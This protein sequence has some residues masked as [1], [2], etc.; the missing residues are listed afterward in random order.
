MAERATQHDV[1]NDPTADITAAESNQSTAVIQTMIARGRRN[2]GEIAAVVQANPSA[3]REILAFLH[4]TLGNGFVQAVVRFLTATPSAAPTVEAVAGVEEPTAAPVAGG[5]LGELRVTAHGL[6]VRSSPSATGHDNIVGSLHHNAMINGLGREGAWV[7]IDF[8][9]KTA[10]VH[11]HYVEPISKKK[12]AEA[13][14]GVGTPVIPKED[15][16]PAPVAPTPDAKVVAPTPVG[17]APVAPTPTPV[18]PTPDAK[19]VAPTPIIAP[20]PVVAPVPDAKPPA[21]EVSH[22]P[23]QPQPEA[24][25]VAPK[26]SAP[27]QDGPPKQGGAAIQKTYR[28]PG[29]PTVRAFLPPGGVKGTVD[30]FMFFHGMYAHHDA[31]SKGVDDPERE[32]HMAEAVAGSG[33][34]LVALAP[35]AEMTK[36]E[37]PMWSA[38]NK[39]QGYSQIVEHC[40]Q[41]L[42][43]DFSSDPALT[44]GAISLA[45]HS[46]GG[47]ALG[48]AAE[49][50]GDA[51]HD[52]TLQDGGYGSDAFLGSHKKL[53][54]WFLTGQADKL[55]RVITH[56]DPGKVNE[57]N[58]LKGFLNVE[59]LEKAAADLKAQ[60][61]KVTL[62]PGNADKRSVDG[63]TLHHRLTVSGLP[64]SRV[65]SVY[66][67]KHENHYEVRNKTMGNLI[68]EG[69]NTDF[70][71]PAGEVKDGPP[72]PKPE[73]EKPAH[74]KHAH[75]G[76]HAKAPHEDKPTPTQAPVV[77]NQPVANK[78][79][80]KPEVKPP[81]P[82]PPEVVVTPAAITG[83]L[84]DLNALVTAANNP[85]ISTVAQ[86][87]ADLVAKFNKLSAPKAMD[88]NE[89]HGDERADLVKGIADV[90][91]EVAGLAHLEIEPAKLDAI[92]G[93]MFRTLQEIS[94][95]HSQGRNVDILE[96]N[97]RVHEGGIKT[98]TCNVTS[99]SMALESIGKGANDYGGNRD[100][101][102]AVA[103]EFRP[104]LK[105]ADLTGGGGTGDWAEVA[106]LRLP[107]FME[108]AAIAEL[109][110]GKTDKASILA[111]GHEAFEQILMMNFLK[112]LSERFGT[113]TEIKYF[114]YDGSQ[115]HTV[116]KK[117][118]T[119]EVAGTVEGD[120]LASQS[121]DQRHQMDALI[122][123]RNKAEALKDGDQKKYAKAEKHYEE[124]KAKA[125]KALHGK[126]IEESI[127]LES[128]KKA[129]TE[130]LG[131]ELASGAAIET[132]VVG[133]FVRLRAIHDDH[134][135]IDDPAQAARAHKKV[136][137]EEARASAMFDK[138]LVIR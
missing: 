113:Q 20:P 62:E 61:V 3:G 72:A 35:A 10:F 15:P 108:L 53:V 130:Q 111:A 118:K 121:K 123:A 13:D 122:D 22:P 94:P 70:A 58:V 110:N 89:F 138:R 57:G 46:A 131:A 48:E 106:K 56:G 44:P 31:K 2:P 102:L 92:K 128:Y 24:P 49:Q 36:A 95:Y 67:F 127:P 83:D 75:H 135:I 74:D 85:Q 99:L 60:G 68:Q 91:K 64:A 1:S 79:D 112:K 134:V 97:A 7:Q 80:V 96:S 42:S 16:T 59:H 137:W 43:T 98:R 73:L 19:V 45:G 90:H 65:V 52:V 54:H 41:Q 66:N 18:A 39:N 40:L 86:H 107:D 14:A 17:P 126:A 23:D 30:V 116:T 93:R 104:E 133:H 100:V 114:S 82:K 125:E 132:H 77:D 129:V 84:A 63:L 38:L 37:W 47:S 119:K 117:G 87:L 26:T 124:L 136:L 33:R 21:N 8:E 88:S 76:H 81:A 25:K 101:L 109:T 6:R 11:G 12:Q 50:L 28:I 105:H 27:V 69:P 32:S 120:H 55:I 71:A 29:L 51:V 4:N 103:K 9:G 5:P 78:P 115:T 34:N